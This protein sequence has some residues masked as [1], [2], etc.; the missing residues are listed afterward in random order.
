MS[1][2]EGMGEDVVC[3]AH[4][5]T[6]PEAP[7]DPRGSSRPSGK[8][9]NSLESGLHGDLAGRASGQVAH[10]IT[11]R[12]CRTS[13]WISDRWPQHAVGYVRLFK[14]YMK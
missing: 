12:R 2:M 13:E 9:M 14:T 6:T 8:G 1:S 10:G 3:V 5:I 4:D 11:A 7:S